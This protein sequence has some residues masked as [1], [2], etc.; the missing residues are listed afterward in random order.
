MD[1]NVKDVAELLEVSVD[2]VQRW[3]SE[4]KI[5]AYRLNAQEYRFSRIEVENWMLQ[6][7]RAS[8]A[9]E[10]EGPVVSKP[11]M[12]HFAL[13]RAVHRGDVLVDVGGESKEELI[14][15]TTHLI[16]ERLGVDADVL[17]ELL[18][19]RESMAPTALGRG[20]AVPHTRD[21]LQKGPFDLIFLI[22]PQMP[23][24][25]GALDHEPVHALFFLFATTDKA[26]LH[27]LAKLAH[28]SSQEQAR[29]FLR[30]K[31]NKKLFLDYVKDWES[32][33]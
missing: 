16:S 1:L 27:L 11:G 9:F 15:N 32:S 3:L 13:F 23:L 31:P 12:Q 30:T 10:E 29:A 19:D 7:K 18:L 2:T 5:P 21:F 33:I 22:Y 4:G 20:I 24:D 6:N 28:L 26:H 25:Y 8:V 17:T 14:K